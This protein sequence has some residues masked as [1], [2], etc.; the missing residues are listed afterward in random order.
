LDIFSP[1]K[2]F[3]IFPR[4][5]LSQTTPAAQGCAAAQAL[6][7]RGLVPEGFK[8][9]I[10]KTRGVKRLLREVGNCLFYFYR[11]QFA[12]LLEFWNCI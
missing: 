8:E 5:L 10:R 4:L 7:G 11:V 12:P 3:P 2:I 9:G 1:E 6:D